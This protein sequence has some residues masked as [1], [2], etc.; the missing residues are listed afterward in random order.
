MSMLW[1]AAPASV[2]NK[3]LP[4]VN[5]H[6]GANKIRSGLFILANGNGTRRSSAT[7]SEMTGRQNGKAASRCVS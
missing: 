1:Y 7:L 6:M 4:L 2:W 3:A 5:G